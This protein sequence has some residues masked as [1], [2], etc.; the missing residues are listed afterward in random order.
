MP[1]VEFD[2]D[3]PALIVRPVVA[4]LATARTQTLHRDA[5]DQCATTL[6]G[7]EATVEFAVVLHM[8][9]PARDRSSAF[10]E[11]RERESRGGFTRVET[12]ANLLE[13][14]ID[15]GHPDAV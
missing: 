10:E 2:L 3:R 6:E 15:R 11:E 1:E 14:V 4:D 7:A 12:L 8:C 5:H 13:Q 9:L